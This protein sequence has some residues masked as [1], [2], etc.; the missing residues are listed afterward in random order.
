MKR[1]VPI[2]EMVTCIAEW[3]EAVYRIQNDAMAKWT[4]RMVAMRK[5][6]VSSIRQKICI[7]LIFNTKIMLNK[8]LKINKSVSV[9]LAPSV[10][11][12]KSQS[13]STPH[14]AKYN[15]EGYV[16]FNEKG[17]IGKLCTANLNATL[18]ETEMDNVLQTAA[19]SL[20][21]LLTYT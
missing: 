10:H 21:T 16:V 4:V 5:I 11:V 8:L 17:T 15:K 2:V 3:E 20:C 14:V 7:K 1:I 13:W 18:P 19:S 9:L 6:A 12:L